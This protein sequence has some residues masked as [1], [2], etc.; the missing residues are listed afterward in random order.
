[1]PGLRSFGAYIPTLRLPR[2]MI[3]KAWS[4]GSLG[5]ERSVANYDEDTLTM[6]VEAATDCLRGVPREEVDGVFFASTTPTY[7]EK[8]SAALIAMALDLSKTVRTADFGHSLRAGTSALLAA[9]DA[10]KA[11][12][13]TNVLVIASDSRLGYPKTDLEQLFGDAAVAVLVSAKDGAV[14]IDGAVS[15]ADEIMDVWRTDKDTYV[16]TWED[17]FAVTYGYTQNVVDAARTLLQ[18]SK[19]DPKGI[20]KAAL[21]SPDSRSVQGV[22]RG[23]GLDAKTQLHPT[24]IDNVGNTGA[25]HALLVLV[26]ALQEAKPGARILAASYGDGSDAFLLTATDAIAGVQKN[27]RG[28]KGSMAVKRTMPTY[29]RYLAFRG[30]AELQPEPP[31]R[32]ASFGGATVEYRDRLSWISMR[33]SRCR[34]CGTHH[35]PIQRVCYTCR[36]KDDYD[37]VRLSDKSATIFNYTLDNLAGGMDPPVIETV[38]ESEAGAC[39][40]YCQMTDAD[41]NEVKI[42]L[43]VE[44][45]FRLMHDVAGFHNYFWKC[46]PQR[47]GK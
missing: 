17:R 22:A 42:G 2:D 13:L 32:I 15:L 16:K 11:G 43:P 24:L 45:T 29:E 19:Q 33:G 46:R 7:K 25:A 8:Q 30:I 12:T 14:R 5:G 20:T 36:A 6:A 10:V 21:Y 18:Q 40:I 34:K 1:M 9:V 47:G 3:A 41:P 38:L 35:Y 27:V 26:D 4:R 37:T 44:F 39:R 31:L 28:V 23:L